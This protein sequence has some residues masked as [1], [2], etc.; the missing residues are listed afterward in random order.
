MRLTGD[1]VLGHLIA[2]VCEILLGGSY[3]VKFFVSVI[4][5]VFGFFDNWPQ[6]RLESQT[7]AVIRI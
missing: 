2:N 4:W 3:Q 1:H 5:D 6:P 7:I